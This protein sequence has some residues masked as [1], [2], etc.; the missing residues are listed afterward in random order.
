MQT[1]ALSIAGIFSGSVM[2][3]L[4]AKKA[5]NL[6]Y[7][8]QSPFNVLKQRGAMCGCLALDSTI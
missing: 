4:K 8:A 6:G 3:C 7:A 1:A 2:I 5:A